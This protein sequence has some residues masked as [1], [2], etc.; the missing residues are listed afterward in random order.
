MAADRYER[1]ICGVVA[2]T[3]GGVLFDQDQEGG[4]NRLQEL[5]TIRTE[6]K[7]NDNVKPKYSSH[8]E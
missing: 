6:M 7:K 3:G 5:G 8:L 2:R 4:G 1:A